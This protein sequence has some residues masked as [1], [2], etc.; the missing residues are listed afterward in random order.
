[1][2]IVSYLSFVIRGVS[3]LS[4]NHFRSYTA[5]SFGL[6]ILKSAVIKVKIP[7]FNRIVELFLNFFATSIFPNEPVSIH[8]F[9]FTLIFTFCTQI[10]VS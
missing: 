3:I 1:M 2:A 5:D 9:G 10:C 8:F 7:F 6:C 4:A